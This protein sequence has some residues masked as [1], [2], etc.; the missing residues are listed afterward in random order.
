V[1]VWWTKA[2][3]RLLDFHLLPNGNVLWTNLTPSNEEH[4]LDGTLA[5]VLTASGASNAAEEHEALLLP[6]GN[7][8]ILVER[9]VAG[10]TFCGQINQ[11]ISDNGFQEIT[12]SGTL[13]RQWYASD[14]IPLTEIPAS[15]CS[16]VNQATGGIYDVYHV[17]SVEPAGG[18]FVLSF[19][20]LDAIY[21]VDGT[22]GTIEWKLGGTPRAGSLTILNDPEFAGGSGFGGQH[23]ARVLS[24]GS[25]TLFDNGFHSSTALRHPPR[26]V[27][28]AIDPGA[29]TATLLEQIKNPTALPS[30]LCCGSARRLSGGDWLIGFGIDNVIT[31]LTSSGSHVFS[32]SFQSGFFSY[33]SHPVM[34]GT[35]SRSSLREGM[36][37]QFPRSYVRPKSATTL[38]VALVPAAQEC[39]APNRTHG[40]PLAFSSCSPP[41]SASRYLTVGTADANGAATNS[42]GFARYGVIAGDPSTS[43]SEADVTVNVGLTDMRRKGDLS[44]YPGQLQVH[45]A[46]RI[47]DRMGGS[48]TL[49]TDF[50]ATVPCTAT[51]ST[52]IGASCLLSSSFNAIVPGSV[53][54]GYRANWELGDVQVFDGGASGV[55]G[56]SDA[57]LFAR[58]GI[59]VP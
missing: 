18:D 13:V 54:E 28:Y 8:L 2:G 22:N 32:L 14:H 57:R 55:A 15:W 27:R 47:T 51:A 56:A 59:F 53:I 3:E 20:H 10:F 5:R 1:P 30:A 43:K 33:R 52:T 21:R 41:T 24:D 34:P 46:V 58:Q 6:N 16:T 12:P 45:S 11:R 35:L 42:S 9:T 39:L 17:N 7:Y 48:T 26:G 31:E 25:M 38:R 36:D 23:D 40:E 37:V 49:D 29:S 50:P 44:D 4:R 19:R